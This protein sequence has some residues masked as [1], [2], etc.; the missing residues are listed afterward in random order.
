MEVFET[1]QGKLYVWKDDKE[2]EGKREKMPLLAQTLKQSS[3]TE[4]SQL[5]FFFPAFV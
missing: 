2:E 3:A 1:V 4:V 5:L